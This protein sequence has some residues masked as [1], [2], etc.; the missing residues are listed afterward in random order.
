MKI[1]DDYL[2]L[3]QEIYDYFDYEEQWR[4]IPI[5]DRRDFYWYLNSDEVSYAE[6]LEDF[7]EEVGNYYADSIYT[8]RHHDQW[9][10][11]KDDYTM[12]MV[13]THCD[14]NKF[15]AI[16]DNTKEQKE[17]PFAE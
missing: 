12:I 7:N 15:L 13:D 11:R 14:G 6:K 5:D 4:V 9:V 17:S 2:K 16:F 3:Q 1:L 10:Y 8:Q